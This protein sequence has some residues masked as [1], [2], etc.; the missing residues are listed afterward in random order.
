[1]RC[2]A[3]AFVQVGLIDDANDFP[4]RSRFALHY[5]ALSYEERVAS[6]SS[7]AFGV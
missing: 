4:G 3:G 6:Y 5:V 1:M 7:R 2:S